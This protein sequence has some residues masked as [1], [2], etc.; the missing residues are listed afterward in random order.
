M[1]RSPSVA[2]VSST[3]FAGLVLLTA[4]TTGRLQADDKIEKKVVEIVKQTG[5]FYKNAKSFHAE[6]TFE[7]KVGTAARSVKSR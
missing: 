2:T 6:G 7:S 4:G 3:L 5:E 1:R